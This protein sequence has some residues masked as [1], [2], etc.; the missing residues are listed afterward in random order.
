MIVQTPIRIYVHFR[1]SAEAVESGQF[2]KEGLELLKSLITLLMARDAV[3]RSS[4]R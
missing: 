2:C 1:S 4:A 3:T